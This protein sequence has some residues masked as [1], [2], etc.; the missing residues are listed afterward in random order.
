MQQSP[1]LAVIL[2]SDTVTR[3]LEAVRG[4]GIQKVCTMY[5]CVVLGIY[6]WHVC[7]LGK[8]SPVEL[9]YQH[10]VSFLSS[11]LFIA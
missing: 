9:Y 1:W 8:L 3:A 5:V 11:V 6:F 4:N 10:T 7:M 2:F